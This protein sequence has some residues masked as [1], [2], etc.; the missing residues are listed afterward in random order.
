MKKLAFIILIL[1]LLGCPGV[2]HCPEENEPPKEG[3]D[4][5]L[6]TNEK[7]FYHYKYTH[8]DGEEMVWKLHYQTL[9]DTN[10]EVN[11]EEADAKIMLERN[12]YSSTIPGN[13]ENFD[14]IEEVV[15]CYLRNSRTITRMDLDGKP[16]LGFFPN[17]EGKNSCDLDIISRDT[18]QIGSNYYMRFT[19]ELNQEIIEGITLGFKNCKIHPPFRENIVVGSLREM[20]YTSDQFQYQWIAE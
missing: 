20:T 12:I 19:N 11:G 14:V 6:N 16:D 10:I 13:E 15:F 8:N 17:L 1:P 2:D 5:F 9:R 4:Q 18:V 3:F 7:W